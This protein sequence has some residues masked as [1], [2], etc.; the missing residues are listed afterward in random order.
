MGAAQRLNRRAYL[1][2]DRWCLPGA[3]P[4]LSVYVARPDSTAVSITVYVLVAEKTTDT[5]NSGLAGIYSPVQVPS[6][7]VARP[8]ETYTAA[9]G[10][11]HELTGAYL[12][13]S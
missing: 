1:H 10:L 8:G 11:Y 12:A 9:L 5:E 7:K 6:L 13:G 4:P 3:V 2:P